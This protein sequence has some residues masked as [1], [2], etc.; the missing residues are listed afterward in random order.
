M[1]QQNHGYYMGG[2]F[3]Q[4]D[5]AQQSD[6]SSLGLPHVSLLDRVIFTLT[7]TPDALLTPE[8]MNK[9]KS[10]RADASRGAVAASR[11]PGAEYMWAPQVGGSGLGLN[12]LIALFSGGH[13]GGG[14][15][16]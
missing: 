2:E 16:G 9:R 6:S 5:Q 12:D 8:D 10:R 1:A 14:G 4:P 7:G 13:G 3:G 15:A 11:N